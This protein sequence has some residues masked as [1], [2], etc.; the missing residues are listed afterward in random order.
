[1]RFVLPLL[2]LA[3]GNPE[4][5]DSGTPAPPLS[6]L[7]TAA[8]GTADYDWVALDSMGDLVDWERM[9]ELD[10]SAAVIRGLLSGAGYPVEL[11]PITY[12][13]RVYRVRY[14]T[15]DRG[16]TVDTTGIVSVPDTDGSFPTVAWLHGTT[17]FSDGCAPSGQGLEGAAGN[18][19]LSSMGAVV[20]AP[21]YLGM[22]GWGEPADFLHPYALA[23]PTAVASLD[24]MRALLSFAAAE[25]MFTMTPPWPPWRLAM[26]LMAA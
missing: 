13:V 7:P 11:L 22:N 1:M 26:R 20:A 4:P 24:A 23:E 25:E 18:L 12:D 15:Q 17:G 5:E 9:P 19:L 8:C 2:I 6:D 10:T 3:C 21:D 16:R 14:L